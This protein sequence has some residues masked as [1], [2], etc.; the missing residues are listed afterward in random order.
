MR[1]D[2]LKLIDNT[3]HIKK[4]FH[5]IDGENLPTH[6][7]IY[8]DADFSI[9]KREVQL[10]LQDIYDRTQGQVYLGCTRIDKAEI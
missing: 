10:E 5:V 9:W 2:L 3:E 7:V 4:K 6:N 1:E 8:N